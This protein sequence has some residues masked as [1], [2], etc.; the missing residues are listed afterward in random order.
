MFIEAA[1]LGPD[2]PVG[3]KLRL[4]EPSA[5]LVLT[6][7]MYLADGHPVQW[8]R[9]IFLPGKL[10]LHVVRELFGYGSSPGSLY[11]P[12]PMSFQDATGRLAANTT[13]TCSRNEAPRA[14]LPSN[15]ALPT[16]KPQ[17]PASA[18]LR[19][20]SS[21]FMLPAAITGTSTAPTTDRT[22]APTSPS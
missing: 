21:L 12:G 8:S 16:V 14:N 19:I 2:D 15:M 5:A 7:T 3:G 10:N 20:L 17:T 13:C 1:I 18:K 4:K 22:S 9:D 6:Q 11:L